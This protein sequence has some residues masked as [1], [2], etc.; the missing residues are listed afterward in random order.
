LVWE[1]H[2]IVL[3]ARS[4]EV[5]QE[6]IK[7][8]KTER[9]TFVKA[10]LQDHQ[11]Q[12]DVLQ[13]RLSDLEQKVKDY[14]LVEN[15]RDAATEDAARWKEKFEQLDDALKLLTKQMRRQ[16]TKNNLEHERETTT[17]IDTQARDN[18]IDRDSQFPGEDDKSLGNVSQED[19]TQSALN[20][21]RRDTS[22]LDSVGD[23]E[24]EAQQLQ[25]PGSHFSMLAA[26]CQQLQDNL[27]LSGLEAL[28]TVKDLTIANEKIAALEKRLGKAE[29]HLCKLWEE[30][31]SIRTSLKK[32]K[33]EKKILVREYKSLI[34]ANNVL[35]SRKGLRDR[36]SE[37]SSL[38]VSQDDGS[39]MTASDEDRLIHEIE[40]S[41]VS[42]IRIHEQYLGT[43]RAVCK[44]FEGTV[45][46]DVN[47]QNAS[48]SRGDSSLHRKINEARPGILAANP[49]QS[50]LSSLF[51]ESEESDDDSSAAASAASTGKID[52]DVVV[53][54]PSEK[55]TGAP[56]P[57]KHA[58]QTDEVPQ[59]DALQRPNPLLQLDYDDDNE[60]SSKP[61]LCATSSQSE[62]SKSMIT[63]N[64]RATARLACPLAD[65]VTAQNLNGIDPM[66]SMQ[67]GRVYHLKFFNRKIG[68]QFQKVPPPSAPTGL[69][70]EAMRVELGADPAD[71][72]KTAAELRGATT[73]QGVDE[74]CNVATPI[75]AVLVCG[76]VGFDDSANR[77]P[78]KL[79]ARLVAFDGISVEV[80]R[81]TFDSIRKAIQARSR[82]LTL[83]FRNDFLT[84]EQRSILTKAIADERSSAVPASA[85]LKYIVDSRPSSTD[86][87]VHSALSH[88]SDYFVNQSDNG[89]RAIPT[90]SNY[91]DDMSS[92]AA[93]EHSYPPSRASFSASRHYTPGGGNLRS[94]SEA[95]SS[96]V[97]SSAFAPLMA[98]LM[99]GV[100][101]KKQQTLSFTP[102][103]MKREAGSLDNTPQHHDFK[104]NLL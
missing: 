70:S 9:L 19:D 24:P 66:E 73:S 23:D 89:P 29:K 13:F 1:E 36:D 40:E 34:Q 5:G 61:H 100:L 69:L 42:S 45:K 101:A 79:G 82:P 33:Q 53:G 49:P 27:R 4:K 28:T 17:D 77:V 58:G 84:T 85:A 83:S 76:L 6:W 88:E 32:K 59:Q 15:D 74:T 67:D 96:S 64:G 75:D 10:E 22:L 7:S 38:D 12:N 65:V 20:T 55:R 18:D 47:N 46:L 2:R 39:V 52:D 81:W 11:R 50:K 68:I 3:E 99:A 98:N 104:S 54:Q 87:S 92:S 72:L 80:G 94:F 91:N 21:S 48:S 97:L 44:E 103:Y 25:I 95:G 16:E 57:N 51:D 93:S 71:G 56:R 30:N 26:A 43:S 62:S 31:C 37:P 8:L 86:P 102:D 41:V 60:E 35:Q 90:F 78:P 63:D 14:H